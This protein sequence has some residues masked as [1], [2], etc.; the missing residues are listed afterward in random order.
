MS[1]NK[2]TLIEIPNRIRVDYWAV[3]ELMAKML[4]KTEE[5]END[6]I[7]DLENEFYEKFEV[8]EEQFHKIVEHLLPYSFISKS[9]L[10][11]KLLIGFADHVKGIYIVKEVLE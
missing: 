5:F 3:Q 7:D 10:T 6:E 8:D 4:N 9:P 2:E 1:K 11:Q